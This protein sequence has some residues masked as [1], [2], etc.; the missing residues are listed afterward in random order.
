MSDYSCYL[1]FDYF[2]NVYF[3]SLT[4]EFAYIEEISWSLKLM[5]CT[6]DLFTLSSVSLILL[7]T[8]I[9]FYWSSILLTSLIAIESPPFL[10]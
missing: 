7:F 6:S 1:L 2:K 4:N 9:L 8:L 10:V 3:Y 5:L